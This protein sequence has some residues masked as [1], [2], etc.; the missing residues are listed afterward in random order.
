VLNNA[1]LNIFYA[2]I[3]GTPEG[4][5]WPGVWDG[6]LWT[7]I[8]E[9]ICYLVVAGLGVMGLLNR[10]WT[11]PA[12]FAL[13]VIGA[14]LVGNPVQEIQSI[15]Q[16]VTRFAVCFSAGALL[17]QFRDKIPARWSLVAVCAVLAVAGGLLPNYRIFVVL[18]LAYAVVVS[19]ALVKNEKLRLRNDVSYGVYIYAWP[20]QQLLAMAGLASLNPFA[21]FAAATAATVPLAI[22]SW[23]LVEKRALSL[24]NRVVGARRARRGADRRGAPPHVMSLGVRDLTEDRE[25]S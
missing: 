23:M 22:A 3:N 6:S 13:S 18:P 21:F 11:I 10:R 17:Y 12:V 8:F 20:M 1:F 5:P 4:V 24:K 19:G 16:M 25:L 15:P 9:M 2:G 7:L 14:A